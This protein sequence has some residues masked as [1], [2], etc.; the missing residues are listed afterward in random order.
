V[1][2]CICDLLNVR[3]DI[4]YGLTPGGW[5]KE[6]K[7]KIREEKQQTRDKISPLKIPDLWN[8]ISL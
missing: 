5:E 3:Q 2:F 7:M 1:V 4:W 8:A 6:R